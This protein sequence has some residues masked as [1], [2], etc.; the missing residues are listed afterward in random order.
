MQSRSIDVF[1][2]RDLT[3]GVHSAGGEMLRRDQMKMTNAL[4][5]QTQVSVVRWNH[6]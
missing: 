4:I 6:L 5:H 1:G 2:G 3:P